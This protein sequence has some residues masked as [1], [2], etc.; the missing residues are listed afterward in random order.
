MSS[1]TELKPSVETQQKD[2]RRAKRFYIGLVLL[3]FAIQATIL[4]TA[5]KLAIGD[6]ALAVVPDYHQAALNW[7]ESYR[8]SLASDRLGWNV[9]VI[10][11]KVSDSK[12]QRAI[13]VELHNQ[14]GK[15]LDD[16]NVDAV[17][18]RHADAGAFQA[19]DLPSMGEGRYLGMA[20]MPQQG[21]WQLEVTVDGAGEPMTLSRTLELED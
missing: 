3:L 6:P 14:Q 19:V 16:L 12:G 7:D 8:A 21:L 18:Y 2:E 5:L 11:S 20:S 10:V 13:S 15:T 17:V 4:G 9:D 1:Q